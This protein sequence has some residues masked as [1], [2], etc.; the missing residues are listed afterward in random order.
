[1]GNSLARVNEISDGGS[2]KKE[3][4]SERPKRGQLKMDSHVKMCHEPLKIM[5]MKK[6]QKKII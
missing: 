2:Q 4:Q 6:Q 1:M 5:N 3:N